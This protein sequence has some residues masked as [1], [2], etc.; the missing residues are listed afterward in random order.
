[1][2][3]GFVNGSDKTYDNY[4]VWPVRSGQYWPFGSLILYTATTEYGTVAVG[5]SGAP[6]Q[7]RLQNKGTS[8]VT[9]TATNLTGADPTPQFT[10]AP[11]GSNACV[12]LTPVLAAGT[13]CTLAVAAAP[14][15]SGAKSAVLTITTAS[16]S[17]DIP[18]NATGYTTLYGVVIDQATGL[19]VAG[20]TVTR[21]STITVTTGTDG[22]YTF[23]AVPVATY[24]ISI[25]KTGYQTT[26]RSGLVV[27]ATAS[28]Q[29]DILLPTTGTL[30]ITSVTLPWASPG[31]PYSS[32]VMVTGG[33]APYTFTTPD[34]L[35]VGLSLDA[36]TGIVSGTPAG[37]VSYPFAIGVTDSAAGYVEK[38][39]TI[40]LLPPLEIA[41]AALP[42]GQQ[43]VAYSSS[44]S[45][46]GGKPPYSY[47]LFAGVM[48][49]GVVLSTSGTISGTAREAGAFAITIKVTEA[50]GRTA[51]KA[52]TLNV[53]AA[54]AVSLNTTTLPPGII[55]T[56]YSATLI[57]TGGVP[58]R[59]F[60]VT[61]TTLLPAGLS[62]NSASG[63]ISGTPS[64]AGLTNLTFTVT[65]YAWPT[66]QTASVTLP[67]RVWNA[68][69]SLNT[70]FLGSGNGSVHSD[71]QPGISCIKGMMTTGCS[72]PFSTGTVVTLTATPE[73]STSTFG[74]WSNA[75]VSVP[76]EITM[77][78]TKNAVAS[79]TLS[80]RTILDLAA[81]TG[82]DTLQTAYSNAA[83]AI[84]ALD[85]LFT[86]T[87]TL[88]Q[89][90]DIALKGGYLADY[91][92][93]R[94]GFTVLGGT[95]TIKN[96]SLRVDRLK[97]GPY[98]ANGL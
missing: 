85:G 6:K 7:I 31:V 56:P 96:G 11:G 53:D 48:P 32:R 51:T 49:K 22:S 86:G 79:F 10:V 91:G 63:V 78:G 55:G 70:A 82:Y 64:A 57:A 59:T 75:C 41:T 69:S 25:A 66:G 39:F 17:M 36:A 35:P 81:T 62:L 34:I 45:A 21:D 1:M 28:A 77:F 52:F 43:A 42:S 19:P 20:V 2:N 80:P 27:T 8:P 38:G 4:Y 88:D 83:T 15:S 65:D 5:S 12:S 16:G 87:W 68:N 73:S 18:L 14:T 24:S 50:T 97:I 13:N 30:N 72:V 74:G 95:L 94:N 40:E 67:L 33:T 3:D 71:I 58:A 46:S 29:A 93:T 92:P 90:K 89:G 61:G 98:T 44:I 60:T 47:A 76:C 37:T 26:T 54:A 9:I 84:F 23:G